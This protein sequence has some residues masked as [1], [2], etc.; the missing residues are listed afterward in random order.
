MIIVIFIY[1]A[2][3]IV[4]YSYNFLYISLIYSIVRLK[5]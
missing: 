4:Y 2:Y 1:K 3:T 5:Q